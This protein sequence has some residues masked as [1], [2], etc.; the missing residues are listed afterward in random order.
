M[1]LES[2]EAGHIFPHGCSKDVDGLKMLSK[3]L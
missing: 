3:V 2:F 1:S